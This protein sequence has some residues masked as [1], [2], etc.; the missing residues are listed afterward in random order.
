[1]DDNKKIAIGVPYKTFIDCV[2]IPIYR[3]KISF[4]GLKAVVAQQN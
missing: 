1:M 2:D 4:E 3:M